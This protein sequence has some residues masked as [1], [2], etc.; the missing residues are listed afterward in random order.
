MFERF[1][2]DAKGAVLDALRRA[3]GHGTQVGAADLLLAIVGDPTC[4]G[5]RLLA[6]HHVSA[7]QV[8]TALAA[9][10]RRAGLTDADVIALRSLGIDADEV[11]RR[12]DSS[13]GSPMPYPETVTRPRR[14]HGLGGPFDAAANGVLQ[15]AVREATV[16][17]HPRVGTE[18]LLLALL[19]HIEAAAPWVPAP[20]STLLAEHAV[21]YEG[22]RRRV[23]TGQRRAG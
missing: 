8:Q 17:G 10:T 15:L 9:G 11:F 2:K 12:L 20:V 13:F 6:Q 4:S 18:H 22:V 19:Q 21:G 14:W 7:A 1:G 16:A 5:A 3:D 23:H